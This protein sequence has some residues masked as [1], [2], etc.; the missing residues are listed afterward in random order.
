V[1]QGI[2]ARKLGRAGIVVYWGVDFVETRFGRGP[3]TSVYERLE[4]YCCRHSDA[5]FELSAE[6]RDARDRRH[7]REGAE[8]VPSRIVPMGGWTEMVPRTEEDGYR[9]R[10]VVYMGH[11][12]PKQGLL[13]LLESI[14]ILR[15][16]GVE[17]S[18]DLIGRGPQEPELRDRVRELDLTARVRFLG[19]V[20]DHR[21]V[22]RLLSLSSVGAAP[23]ATGNAASY[24]IYADPGK[25]KVYL[26][27]GLPIVTTNAAPVAA[28][29]ARAGAALVV[30]FDPASIAAAIAG[31]LGSAPEWR[32]HRL[33][34]LKVSRNYNWALI[35]S[36]ALEWIGFD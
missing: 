36:G 28:E 17:V 29:L 8:L 32:R 31:L 35:L 26:A 34:A 16:Q 6:M 19:Y 9:R 1:V 21:E 7:R 25:L 30:D 22:E 10:I 20:D 24:T 11:L 12:L 13:E 4:G 18:L 3:L 27:A 2:G 23:Y 5:R 15:D 33:A 14:R